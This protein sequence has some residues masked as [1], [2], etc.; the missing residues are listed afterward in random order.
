MA[1]DFDEP[2]ADFAEYVRCLLIAQAMIEKM[3]LVSTDAAFDAY[4]T[5]RLS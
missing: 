1:D 4:P 2:L 3:P 5:T